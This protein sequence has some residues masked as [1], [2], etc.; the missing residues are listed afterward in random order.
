M[1]NLYFTLNVGDLCKSGKGLCSETHICLEMMDDEG[2][3]KFWEKLISGEMTK[4]AVDYIMS[5][6]SI[7]GGAMGVALLLIISKLPH[8]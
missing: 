2:F 4:E 1:V 3:S 5:N 7:I 6:L 8:L